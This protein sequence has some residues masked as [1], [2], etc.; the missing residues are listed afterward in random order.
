M[1]Y[2]HTVRVDILSKE[3][4]PAIYGGAGV[5]VAELSRVLAPLV[6][7]NVRCFGEPREPDFHGAHVTAYPVP[8]ELVAAN[9]AVQTLG[10]DLTMIQDV[11]GADLVVYDGMFTQGEYPACRGWGHSTWEK[12]VELCRA[13]GVGQL[14]IIHLYPQ[15]TDAMLLGMEQQLKAAMP[16]AF[17][18]RE[19]QEIVLPALARVPAV[20]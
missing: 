20:A 17:I 7:L 15:H 14:A 3:F 2:A 12:G 16:T 1:Q 10:V 5:H 8:T 4:P 9:A 19:R 18:A 11:E 6:D 13:A